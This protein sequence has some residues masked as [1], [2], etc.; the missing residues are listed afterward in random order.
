MSQDT[1]PP[2]PVA[3]LESHTAVSVLLALGLAWITDF[4]LWPAVPGLSL[5]I[6]VLILGFCQLA[7]RGARRLTRTAWIAS[8]VL[9]VSGAQMTVEMSLSNT[10]VIVAAL[11]ALLG[12]RLFSDLPEWWG[13]IAEAE[14]VLVK[15]PAQW[16][17]AWR[18]LSGQRARISN[19]AYNHERQITRGLQA[20]A[21]ALAIGAVF[22]VVLGQGNAILRE[23]SLNFLDSISQW[24]LSWDLSV[25]RVAFWI[26]VATGALA[27]VRPYGR[28]VY[29]ETWSREIPRWK[30][31]DTSMAFW[32]TVSVLGVLNVLFFVVNTIDVFYLWLHARIPE[33]VGYSTYVHEGVG[34]LIAAVLLSAVVLAAAFRQEAPVTGR[35]GLKLLAHVWII[36]NLLL[37][38]G[39]FLRLKLY[40]DAYQLTLLRVYVGCFLLLVMAGFCLLAVYVQH[41]KGMVWLITSNV[42]VTLALFFVLQFPDI[43]GWVARVN[44]AEWKSDLRHTLDLDYLVALGPTAWLQLP[45]VAAQT[46]HAEIVESARFRLR[47]MPAKESK[48]LLH[49]DWRSIQFRRDAATREFVVAAHLSQN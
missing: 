13:Q 45:E 14:L 37:I 36:Q 15:A 25:G 39:V 11:L 34:S 27:L 33:N 44:V 31:E 3:H 46:G 4:L 42:L 21:P 18:A 32:Q 35:R 41:G 26:A 24:L 5:G 29:R 17:A 49:E 20:G 28:P 48:R 43:A 22:L 7:I 47:H 10:I 6:L 12:E 40:V 38:A 2:L 19:A 8:L 9:V 16:S 30:R 23:W 1:P